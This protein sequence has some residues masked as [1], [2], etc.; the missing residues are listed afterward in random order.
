MESYLNP[1]VNGAFEDKVILRLYFIDGINIIN[2]ILKQEVLIK[3]DTKLVGTYSYMPKGGHQ[4]MW[5][6]VLKVG[7]MKYGH[8]NYLEEMLYIKGQ[9]G[10]EGW[11]RH[12]CD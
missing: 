7:G 2:M 3:F 5:I 6:V 4:A 9:L 1:I 8:I 10:Y 12:P 11:R